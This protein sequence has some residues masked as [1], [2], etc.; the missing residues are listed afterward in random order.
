M[1]QCR[2]I[3]IHY[4]DGV[5]PGYVH[6][7]IHESIC[8]NLRQIFCCYLATLYTEVLLIIYIHSLR[9]FI[10]ELFKSHII[11][12]D[13]LAGMRATVVKDMCHGLR[14]QLP[15]KEPWLSYACIMIKKQF[16]STLYHKPL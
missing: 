13:I 1:L 16:R 10:L 3:I 9:N 4:L 5:L 6:G 15:S 14:S 12:I 11:S 2:G 8:H 7:E